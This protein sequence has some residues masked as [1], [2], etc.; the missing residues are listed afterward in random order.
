MLSTAAAVLIAA[1]LFAASVLPQYSLGGAAQR[2]TGPA[3][4]AG[5][6]LAGLVVGGFCGNIPSALGLSILAVFLAGAACGLVVAMPIFFHLVDQRAPLVLAALQ[7][8]A[9]CVLLGIPAA[10]IGAFAGSFLAGD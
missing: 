2:V 10:A 1:N 5:A 4:L 6:L 7:R 8:S 9:V 3:M